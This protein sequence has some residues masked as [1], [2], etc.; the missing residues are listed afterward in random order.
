MTAAGTKPKRR[1]WVGIPLGVVISSPSGGGKST[2]I[3]RLRQRHPEFLY[4]L[5]VTTRAPRSGERNGVH[6]HFVTKDEFDRLR[7]DDNLLEWAEVHGDFY[8]TPRTNV[9]RAMNEKRVLLFDIDVQGAA[10]IRASEPTFVTIFLLPPSM[11]EL[12]R[13]L[14]GRGSESPAQRKRR[15]ETAKKELKRV[16]EYDYWVTNDQLSTCVTDCEAVIRAELLRRSR[17]HDSGQVDQRL[18]GGT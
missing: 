16:H 12:K 3:R 11:A 18:T 9:I 7:R 15:L 14:A 8:G 2:V 1:G 10:S 17:R 6:Y 4:S 5:S 13:R